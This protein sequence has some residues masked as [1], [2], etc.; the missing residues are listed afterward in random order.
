M[1]YYTT[2]NACEP[3]SMYSL[4]YHLPFVPSLKYGMMYA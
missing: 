1:Q 3:F 4:V 2:M